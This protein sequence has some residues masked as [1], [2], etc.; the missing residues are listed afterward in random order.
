[1]LNSQAHLPLQFEN[2][3]LVKENNTLHLQLIQQKEALDSV[4]LKWKSSMRSVQ[5]EAQDL[6]YL[7]SQKDI[8]L[9]EADNELLKMKSKLNKVLSK[10]YM[11]GQDQV[12]GGMNSVGLPHNVIRGA[13]QVMEM[14]HH[15]DS[16]NAEGEESP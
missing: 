13:Q 3:R 16:E 9:K 12:L 7:N 6:V 8:K 2:E 5:N 14:N 10:L 11:P 4:E 1:V 15:L